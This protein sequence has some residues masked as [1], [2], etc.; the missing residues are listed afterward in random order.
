MKNKP[1]K[2]KASKKK[3]CTNNH[4]NR[5]SFNINS[6][7]ITAVGR[8]YQTAGSEDTG[9]YVIKYIYAQT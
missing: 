6:T 1:F 3:V 5:A 9:A 8:E 2:V 4:H 7:T